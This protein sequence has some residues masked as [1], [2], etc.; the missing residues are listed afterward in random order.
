MRIAYLTL[1]A[2]REG[3]AS[4]AHVN[5]I[6]AGLQRRSLDVD[7]YQPIY[8]DRAT[9]PGTLRRIFEYARLQ[10]SLLLR[11]RRY[12]LIYVRSH[13]MAFPVALA[14]RLTDRAIIHEINGPY[15]DIMVTYPWTRRFQGLLCWLERLQN[16]W[17]DAL[18]AVTP[19]LMRWLRAEGCMHLIEV[20]PNGANL[21]HFNPNLKRRPDLPEQYAVFFGG[22]A[23]WQGITTMI[24]AVRHP[25]WPAD[26]PL[27][28][29]GDGQMRPEVERAAA[30]E[31]N[32][33]YLGKLPYIE[34]GS[35]VVGA[36]A[37][38]VPKIR[39][40]DHDDTGLFPVKLFEI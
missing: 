26:V 12:D 34:V 35:V 24:D 36:L 32:L 15:I 9:A 39:E 20:I 16:R 1:E 18:V 4:Y 3:Q 29:V 38:L 5:E 27:V 2:P 13:F 33:L 28:I 14:A 31:K 8:T 37:S 7:L 11:W 10:V 6:V 19:Q 17:A 23:R 40:N 30:N 25:A 22:F 21:T